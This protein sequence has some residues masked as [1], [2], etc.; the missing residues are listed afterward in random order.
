MVKENTEK[1]ERESFISKIV[2]KVFGKITNLKDPGPYLAQGYW[3]N[4][5]CSLQGNN[6]MIALIVE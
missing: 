6:F 5:F 4:K 3:Q 2:S 1:S